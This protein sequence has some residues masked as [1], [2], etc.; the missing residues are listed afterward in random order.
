[1]DTGNSG[2]T[3]EAWF[4]GRLPAGTPAVVIASLIGSCAT[5]ARLRAASNKGML[6]A[7]RAAADAAREEA[8]AATERLDRTWLSQEALLAR[9]RIR[10]GVHRALAEPDSHQPGPAPGSAGE[11]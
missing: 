9:W 5:A 8:S 7:Q 6:S 4:P 2:S 1:M 10:H 11:P 3:T